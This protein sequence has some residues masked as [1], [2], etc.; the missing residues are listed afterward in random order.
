[1]KGT[2]TRGA[3]VAQ[4]TLRPVWSGATSIHMAHQ[5]NAR[6]TDLFCEMAIEAAPEVQWPQVSLNRDLWS[7]LDLESRRCL[8]EFPFVIVDLRFRDVD[9]WHNVSTD[10]HEGVNYPDGIRISRSECLVLETLMFAW[11]SAR[12]DPS[13]AQMFF[14]M[15]PP[16]AD[17]IAAMT[18]QQVR[19]AALLSAKFLRIRWEGE[20]R[21][22]RE[23]LIAARAAD[24]ESLKALRRD[25]KLLFVG[26][27]IQL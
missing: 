25:A 15:A 8:A 22:W 24:A 1:M 9:W 3:A 13:V 26:E 11:Q 2:S 7:R 27:L 17:G 16:V 14:A 10:S 18:M 19:R 21:F 12:E 6:Y 5:L 4:P 20:P 23:L